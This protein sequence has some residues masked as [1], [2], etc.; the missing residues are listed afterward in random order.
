MTKAMGA[1]YELLVYRRKAKRELRSFQSP[2]RTDDKT[3]TYRV[4]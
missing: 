2:H 1:K 4:K 3:E